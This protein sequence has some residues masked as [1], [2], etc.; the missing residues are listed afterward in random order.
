[1]KIELEPGKYIVAV[2]GGVDS[3]VLL[4]LL[5]QKYQSSVTSDLE[6]V[7][8]V[9]TGAQVELVVAHFDHGI[10]ENSDIDRVFVQKLA[11]SYDLPFEYRRE[12]LGTSA[13]EALARERRYLFLKEVKKQYGAKAIITAHHKDDELET[14]CINMVRG[15]F[16][17]GISSLKSEEILRPLLLYSKNEILEYAKNNELDW[18]EDE[19]NEDPKYLRNF[20]RQKLSQADNID[21]DRLS[22]LIEQAK[23]RNVEMNKLVEDIFDYGFSAENRSF[24]RSYFISLPY[25]VSCE[26]VAHWLRKYHIEFDKKNIELLVVGLKTGLTSTRLDAGKGMFFVLSAKQISLQATSS[27]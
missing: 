3:V 26:I 2:S 9:D 6:T 13:S 21:K 19:T 20:I 25:S 24:D 18:R 7:K 5:T 10:R 15:T 22:K 17:R 23:T 8:N 4:H 11:N 14:A 1:M 27:V 12:E 16:R